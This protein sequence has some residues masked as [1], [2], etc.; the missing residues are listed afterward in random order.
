LQFDID[1][2]RLDARDGIRNDKNVVFGVS[3]QYQ[4]AMPDKPGL[5]S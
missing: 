2:E 1:G 4:I 3:N 5:Q